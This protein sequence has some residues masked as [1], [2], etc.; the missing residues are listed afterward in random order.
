VAVSRNVGRGIWAVSKSVVADVV[1]WVW[2]LGEI[3]Y[4]FV[5]LS[6]SRCAGS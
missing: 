2:V 6:S 3:G 5:I 4:M 1:S